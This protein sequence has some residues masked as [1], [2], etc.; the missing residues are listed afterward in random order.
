MLARSRRCARLRRAMLTSTKAKTALDGWRWGWAVAVGAGARR[1]AEAGGGR[2]LG[3]K[4]LRRVRCDVW[5][6]ER[7]SV[8]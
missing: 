5:R 2:R 4:R 6:F 3:G 8:C 7:A 1:Q